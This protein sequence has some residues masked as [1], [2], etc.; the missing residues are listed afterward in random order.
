[1]QCSLIQTILNVHEFK[2]S[3]HE[4][5]NAARFHHQW[6][7]DSIRI[8]SDRFDNKLKNQLL[9]YGYKLNDKGLIGRVD[10]ILIKSNKQLEA[11]A[12]N[13]GDDMAIGF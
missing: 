8:E 13:R 3:M 6:M 1:M 9:N 7:P 5:V 10:G 12:D 2:M 4:A 11:G